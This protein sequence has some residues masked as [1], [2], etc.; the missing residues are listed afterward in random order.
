[1]NKRSLEKLKAEVK[2]VE[3]GE[4]TPGRIWRITK[5][6]DGT[7]ERV[8]LDPH[9]YRLR[10]A[11]K[12]QAADEPLALRV[13]RQMGVSQDQFAALFGI[14]AGTLRNWEQKRRQ[15]TGAAA[16]LLRVAARH[17]DLVRS[18]AIS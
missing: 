1:M 8:Q 5:R 2:A 6:L 7:Y 10:Q 16:L 14:S 15:P 18:I 11:A 12:R 13:R 9:E 4:L 17:P 3:N